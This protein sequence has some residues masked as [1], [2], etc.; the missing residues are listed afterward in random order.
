MCTSVRLGGWCAA[1]AA[2]VVVP[3]ATLAADTSKGIGAF[4]P[5]YATVELFSA[6]KAGQLDVQ[7]IPKDASHCKLL[8]TNK[9]DK[10]LNVKLPEVMA[11]VP[12]LAQMGMPPLAPGGRAANGKSKSNAPQSLAVPM[13]NPFQN[14]NGNNNNQNKFGNVGN[15]I[16]NNIG[17]NNAGNNKRNPF[18]P[19]S[20]A[21]ER[22]GQLKLPALCLEHGKPEPKAVVPYELK[23]IETVTSKP[24]LVEVC[25]MLG[26]GEI[27]QK[28]AQ[29]A[30]WH[31]ANDM[32]WDALAH[33][34]LKV[35]GAAAQSYFSK[36]EIAA[37]KDAVS[38]ASESLKSPQPPTNSSAAR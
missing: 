16:G 22:V 27:G 26:H 35:L 6:I 29:A 4:D 30:A 25:R 33:K 23:P 38:K 3:A 37:A 10:P 8:V 13:Q 9:S 15:N 17:N 12:A 34:Q 5:S 24:E 11:A 19:F 2:V 20:I 1:L 14:V 32:S 21:P 18:M 28:A 36:K 7:V 31:L